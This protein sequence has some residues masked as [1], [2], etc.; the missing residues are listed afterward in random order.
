MAT[1]NET[2]E[3]LQVF[4]VDESTIESQVSEEELLIS[5][6]SIRGAAKQAYKARNKR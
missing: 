5:E 3:R 4:I 2:G 6:R 1:V